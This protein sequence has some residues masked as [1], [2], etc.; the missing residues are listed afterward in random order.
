[1]CVLIT[2][3]APGCSIAF[4]SNDNKSR[5]L[6]TSSLFVEAPRDCLRRSS[7]S[8]SLS[9]YCTVKTYLLS[10][11]SYPFSLHFQQPVKR[12]RPSPL[13]RV[14]IVTQDEDHELT[15]SQPFASYRMSPPI[16]RIFRMARTAEADRVLYDILPALRYR[17]DVMPRE[18]RSVPTMNV[19][20][21]RIHTGLVRV[22]CGHLNVKLVGSLHLL[23]LHRLWNPQLAVQ[24]L[25][26][27]HCIAQPFAGSRHT[28][29]SEPPQST[30]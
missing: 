8:R 11:I 17:D 14:Q 16:M 18:V 2:R 7:L 5:A 10:D 15:A 1:M 24:F 23:F 30:H 26:L 9:S 25:P 6:R 4:A 13:L 28:K 21:E 20:T 19:E 27:S 3:V 22:D 29:R 12:F